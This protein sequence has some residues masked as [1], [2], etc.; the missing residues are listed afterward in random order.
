M[1]KHKQFFRVV[2]FLVVFILLAGNVSATAAPAAQEAG[3]V[4]DGVKEAAWG[5]ALAADPQ[6]D[7][8]EPNLD[9]QGLYVVEDGDNYYIGFD[10]TASNW[11]MTFGIYIDTDQVDGS[12]G[13]SDP[14]GRAVDAVSAHLPEHTL[15]VYHEDFDAL[16]DAQLNHWDG[17]GWSYDS[18][19]AQGGEQGY[20]PDDDWIEYRVPKALLGDPAAIALEV[21]TTGGDGHAQDSVPSDPNI[22]YADP[23]WSGDITTLSA[24][25]VF[26]VLPPA[27]WYV[28]GD[29]NGWDTSDPM[30]DDGLHGDA[31][32]GDGIYTA[33]VVVSTTGRYEFK[34]ANEDWSASYPASGNCWLETSSDAETVVVSFDTN[35]TADG[36]LPE[37]DIIGVSTEPGAWTAVGDWQ[38]WDNANPASSMM[39]RGD[40]IYDLTATVAAP[41]SYQ[42]KAVK[43]GTWDAVG[44][45]GRGVN[46][47]TATFE[48]TQAD[49]NVT[50]TVDALTGRI[51]VAVE[52][53]P[54]VPKP[55]DNI[56]WDGLGHDSRSDLYRLP[57]GAVTTGTPV[58]VRFRT[59]HDDVTQVIVRVWSTAAGAQTLI[60]MEL[61]ATTDEPPYGYD[62]WQA[63]IP[64]QADP[65]ILYY[66]FIVR[67]GNDE[68]FYEDDDF[69]DGGWGAAY[70]DSPDYSY[71][72]DVYDPG[73]QT[74]EWMKNAV[75][76]QIFP[77]RFYNGR[78][79]NDA[80][81]DDPSVYGNSVVV[82]DWSD[83]PEGYCRAYTGGECNEE[84]MGRDF[85]GGDLRG[86]TKK[87]KY[88]EELGVTAIYLNPI[89]MAPSNHLYDT[90][91]YYRIDP[92][93][94]TLGDYLQLMKQA[95]KHGIHVIL[96]GVFN[97]TSS[98]SLYF[99][100][101]SRYYALGAYESQ[102]SYFYDWYTFNEWPDDYNSWWGFD[103]LPV[104]T[105]NQAVRNFIYAGRYS[106]APTWL[107]LRAAGWRLDVAPDKSHDWWQE[108]RTVVKSTNPNA[109]IIGEIWDDASPW[110]LGDEFDSTMNYRFR[111]AL[112]G[113]VNGDTNDPNQGFIQGL[114]PD[115][116]NSVLQSIKE[117][118]P[119]P[120]FEAAMNLVGT[121]DT[122]RILWA[123]T[124]GER[125]QEDKEFN[126]AN[127]A[128]G[129]AKLKLLALIQM[130]LPGAPTI[131]YG[132][133]VGLT[134]DTDPDDRRPF[135]WNAKD[136]DL[137][138]H[139]Q[140]LTG[141]RNQYSFLRTG[142][143]DH[144]YTHNDNG[145]YAYGRKDLSGAAVVAVNRDATAHELTIDVGGYIPEGIVLVDA[146]N[147][148]EYT[149]VDGQVTLVVDGRWGAVLVT[150]DGI[151]LTPPDAPADL[152]GEAGNGFVALNWQAAADAVGYYVYR[153]PV[154]GGGYLRL[155]DTPVGEITFTDDTVT[156]GRRF[157]YVVT[158]V[159]D[160]GNESGH[161]NEVEAL[162]H[163]VIGWANL[164]WPPS[165]VHTIGALNPTENIY[166]QVWIDSYTNLPG[167]TE[168]LIAQVGYGPDGSDPAGNSD[169]I[170]VSAQFNVDAGNNDEFRGQLL[171]EATGIYDYA[172]RYSTTAGTSWEY[173]DLD[174]IGNGYDP[175]KAG[176]L[177]VEPSADTTAPG[178]PG[179]LHV[180][181]ASPSFVSLAWDAVGDGDL[182][183]YEVYRSES[184]GGPYY[185]AANVPAPT[186]SY[187]DWSVASGGTYYYVVLA[188][189]TSFNRSGY[190]NEVEATAQARQVQVTFNVTLPDTTPAGEDVYMGGN[191]NG[192]DPAGTLLERSDLFATITI[193]LN[194][195]EQ[196]EYKYTRGSWDYVEK[197]AA[198]E[199]VA[200]RTVTVVYGADGKMVVD[201]TVLN[202][203]NTGTCGE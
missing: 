3:I 91:N 157:F 153:S 12:G 162:P 180:T 175:A 146:L 76:Y 52:A 124:P 167:A 111:R 1:N 138:A 143:F 63:P 57:G 172:Y 192:W 201:D 183:R 16:Q 120:A 173:A 178:V 58:I 4:I 19:I 83:L 129:K 156:N 181:E 199:E 198:C 92:Y 11:G 51:M 101:Y 28:R 20:A 26:P 152:T 65:T 82:K 126:E 107:R 176:D 99:D 117:D 179:N 90:T 24:F 62:Y 187:T 56:W 116:F 54:E 79:K 17:S 50:F 163:L 148:G 182:Y 27:A 164:Q 66:R 6:G 170:W 104:L 96:D 38:G 123:L 43:T 89:F 59:Y 80:D 60:P 115:Q 29:F 190:S 22:A 119:A 78:I 13:I 134:G 10:A 141:I 31:T 75:V 15:Y 184:A 55:D 155:N 70:E 135:P 32:A 33:E 165:I 186:T 200:N 194:E 36:W 8:S 68:D 103:S 128:E 9:L 188:V 133:E 142:S 121:H 93:F 177:V 5:D 81:S 35:L 14:W 53:A 114:T 98:D 72:I 25:A 113:F 73:F 84:P 191:F 132:D 160:V 130:T 42:Y 154:T 112:I 136:N 131:Y 185:L 118:Y 34:I 197:G 140:A 102:D 202:W 147:G 94:G 166:G 7:I 48:T 45:D 174:G 86:I 193:T 150:P 151:D 145:T 49:Q 40:G 39:P 158:A 87:L 127:L 85:F 100:K 110:L 144:L 203:R 122:Q 171:P 46:A 95:E 23:D 196:L 149:V 21:F 30:Y 168:G 108:F 109:V 71:Q 106:V 159:D 37:T 2:S 189:D 74:P 41:G 64:A 61:V 67:D 169:W 88:L 195:G 137:L 69:F 77:D 139:Y 44:A 105:E 161:S 47:G 97:H 125:N 18:L